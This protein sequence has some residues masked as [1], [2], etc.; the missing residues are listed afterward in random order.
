VVAL[1][2]LKPAPH[3]EESV[4]GAA[5]FDGRQRFAEQTFAKAYA[6]VPDAQRAQAT[7]R[8]A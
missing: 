1:A 6:A 8:F 2:V 5:D 3:T 4:E 7:L